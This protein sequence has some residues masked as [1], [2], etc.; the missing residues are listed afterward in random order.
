[1]A[2]DPHA[3]EPEGCLS[4][5]RL[6]LVGEAP[7]AEEAQHGRPFVGPAGKALRDM[8]ID[9]RI[10]PAQLRM[11][12]ALPFRPIDRRS[13]KR[14]RNRAPTANELAVF[15]RF[16][17]SD[18]ERSDPAVILALGS[19]AARLFG[20]QGRIQQLRKECLRFGGRSLRVSYHPAFVRRFAG[21]NSAL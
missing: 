1:M 2:F 10:D 21:R 6:Y 16:V 14:P 15:S 20:A 13:S 18:I 8:L 11:A 7:G 5:P 19:S 4:Q 12:N 17:L 3:V 9:A